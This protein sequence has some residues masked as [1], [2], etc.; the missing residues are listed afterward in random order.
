MKNYDSERKMAVTRIFAA[1]N[2]PV[3]NETVEFVLD[4]T[5][6]IGTAKFF[7]VCRKVEGYTEW[8]TNISYELIRLAGYE[9]QHA[10]GCADCCCYMD[11]IPEMSDGKRWPF[12]PGMRSYREKNGKHWTE[13]CTCEAGQKI[14]REMNAL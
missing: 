4:K 9:I 2:K 13:P 11:G 7:D 8:P 10:P 14:R 5:G 3:K 6:G 1:F 12:A